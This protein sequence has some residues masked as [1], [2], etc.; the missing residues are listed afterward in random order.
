MSAQDGFLFIVG[1]WFVSGAIVGIMCLY[2][3]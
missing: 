2:K 1:S 3:W